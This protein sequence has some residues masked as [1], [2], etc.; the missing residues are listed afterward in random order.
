MKRDLPEQA[1]PP[2]PDEFDSSDESPSSLLASRAFWLGG[3]VSLAI[4]VGVISLIYLA[5]R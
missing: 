4:W 1:A 3:L 2:P 5:L